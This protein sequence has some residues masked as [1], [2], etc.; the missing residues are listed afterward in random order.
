MLV[1][2]YLDDI[3]LLAKSASL[4]KRHTQ[5]MLQDLTESGMLIN[6]KKSQ[7]EPSQQVELLGFQLDLEKGVLQVPTQKLKAVCKELGKFIT[8]Q[9]MTCRKAAAILGQL[10]SF[11]TALPCLRAFSDLLVKFTERQKVVGW[12]LSLPIPADLKAQVLEIGSLLKAWEGRAFAG[13]S[14]VRKIHSD[15]STQGWGAIDLTSGAKLHEFWRTEMGLHINI[16]ELK[17]SIAAVQSLAQPGET[18]YLSVDN[19][20]AY[21]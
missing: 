21:S 17:A 5:V 12:D 20:V 4:A 14:P 7:T 11:L 1:F 16:K 6:F 13:R 15:S 2:V 19:Q 9:E 18:V 10:R 8:Q 3:L